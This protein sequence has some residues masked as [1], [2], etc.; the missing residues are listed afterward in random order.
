VQQCLGLELVLFKEQDVG[1]GAAFD[2]GFDRLGQNNGSGVVVSKQSTCRR[3]FSMGAP[4]A[5]VFSGAL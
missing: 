2:G 4:S 5:R 1:D 3:V